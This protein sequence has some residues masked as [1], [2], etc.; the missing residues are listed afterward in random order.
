MND[1]KTINLL[2]IFDLQCLENDKKMSLCS[3]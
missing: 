3:L 1:D 2:S